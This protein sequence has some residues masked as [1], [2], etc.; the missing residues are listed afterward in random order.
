MKAILPAVIQETFTVNASTTTT[1]ATTT[2]AATIE[3]ITKLSDG[4]K[5]FTWLNWHG[6]QSFHSQEA[7]IG[8]HRRYNVWSKFLE[9]HYER[10][11]G[12]WKKEEHVA[13]I[14]V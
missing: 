11:V 6:F 8:V 2:V 13:Q 14:N 9:V 5:I 7:K 1:T 10:S 4:E 12:F 3:G